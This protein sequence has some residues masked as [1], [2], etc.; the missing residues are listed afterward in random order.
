MDGAAG[1]TRHFPSYTHTRDHL[2][3][4]LDAAGSGLV[5]SV[6]R[7]NEMFVVVRAEQQR[8]MLSLLRPADAQ[9]VAEGGGWA[10]IFPG[11][12]VHGDGDTFD[13]AVDDALEALR[14]YAQAWN[15]DLHTAANHAD[16]RAVVELIELSTDDELRS[17]VLGGEE[18]RVEVGA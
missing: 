6:T 11:L 8:K 18:P 9:V 5:T 14:E 7:G 15:D 13:G 1:V 4:V 12:S 16:N 2:R 17:W 3:D 10:V